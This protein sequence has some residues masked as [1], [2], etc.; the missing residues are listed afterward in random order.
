MNPPT[1]MYLHIRPEASE[2][3]EGRARSM[4]KMRERRV[5]VIVEIVIQIG[6]KAM[7]GSG[8]MVSGLTW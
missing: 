7:P 4:G 2:R 1:T 8:D 6:R 3:S 5:V